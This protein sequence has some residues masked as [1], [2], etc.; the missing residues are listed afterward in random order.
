MD[1]LA[2][3]VIDKM[4]KVPIINKFIVNDKT[5]FAEYKKSQAA[6]NFATNGG[7]L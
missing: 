4:G 6:F 5:V 7:V 1:I 3:K 2:D